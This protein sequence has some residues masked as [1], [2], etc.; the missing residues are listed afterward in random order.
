MAPT[1][2][3]KKSQP[4]KQVGNAVRRILGKA[5][6]QGFNCLEVTGI[7]ARRF[8]GM[9]AATVSA[10]KASCTVIGFGI[11]TNDD[12]DDLSATRPPSR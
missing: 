8:L 1:A 3:K 4:S 5:G 2:V 12:G 7:V 11:S 6:P 10:L 9:R